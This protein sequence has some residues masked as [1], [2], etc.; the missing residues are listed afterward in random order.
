LLTVSF[1]A[2]SVEEARIGNN[3]GFFFWLIA[4]NLFIYIQEIHFM[5]R[6]L[7]ITS[8]LLIGFLWVTAASAEVYKTVDKN[9]RITY[10]DVP[11]ANTEAKPVALK[12]INSLPAPVVM[13]QANTSSDVVTQ[14][15]LAYHVQLLTPENGTTLM[16]NQRSVDVSVGLNQNLNEGDM[17]AY[18]IDGTLLTTTRDTAYTLTE[19]PR[20]EHSLSVDVVDAEGNI[21]AQSAAITLLV[22]RP[23]I[24]QKPVPVPK[25][26]IVAPK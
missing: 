19:P 21:L 18:K 5:L 8:G 4:S 12:T 15:A 25:K 10:T 26:P 20:G 16:P 13:P 2:A 24:K 9:G 14:G 17:L 7:F 22:M 23:F 3:A 11:P 6:T 1:L